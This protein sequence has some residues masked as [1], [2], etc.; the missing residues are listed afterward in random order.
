M[1]PLGHA[2]L[3][4]VAARRWGADPR[5]AALFALGPDLLDKP[6]SVL[7]P[8]LVS[9]NTR[10]FGHTALAAAVLLAALLA[11][12]GRLRGARLLWCCWA[13]HLVLDRMWLD[14]NPVIFYW[15]LRGAFPRPDRQGYTEHYLDPWYV[16]G[17]LAGLLFLVFFVRRHRLA[18]RARLAA[19]LRTGR[20]PG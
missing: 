11:A 12:R 16:G 4:L 8:S 10:N 7:V 17:E 19:F 18:D 3:A 20:L 13:G 15:P 2:G 14:P 9:G 5:W 6:L 1:F